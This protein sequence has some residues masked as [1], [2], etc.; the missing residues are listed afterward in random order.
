MRMIL[1]DLDGTL[2]NS[3]EGIAHSVNVTRNQYGFPS[4]PVEEITALTGN[5]ARDLLVRSFSDVTLPVPVEKAL[6][7]MVK[8][9]AADP[10]YR[11]ELYPG[12][13][14]GLAALHVAGYVLVVVSNKP[15]EVGKKILTGLNIASLLDLNIGGG[16]FPLKP[17]P[18]ALLWAMAEF[19]VLPENA[20]MVGDNHTDLN[21]AHAAGIRSVFCRYGFGSRA[22]APATAEIDCFAELLPLVE[23]SEATDE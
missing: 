11:T 4:R 17:A 16:R 6:E 21:A 1:F 19:H 2:I 14:E 10:L 7:S 5:G 20:W 15:E 18:D 22:A 13:Y 8:N 9:Y 3:V 23:Y 12:V